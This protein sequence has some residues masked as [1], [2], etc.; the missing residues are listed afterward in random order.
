MSARAVP[1]CFDASSL[2]VW[3][4][5][6]NSIVRFPFILGAR[7]TVCMI[8]NSIISTVLDSVA[9]TA[10]L[11]TTV[12]NVGRDPVLTTVLYRICPVRVLSVLDADC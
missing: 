12:G 8:T 4:L 2:R 6:G 10:V 9:V 3:L 7:I 1:S 11:L 5:V